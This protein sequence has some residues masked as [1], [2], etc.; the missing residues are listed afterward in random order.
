MERRSVVRTAA[1]RSATS[2]A[3]PVIA[4]DAMGGDH[5]P[6]EIVAGAAEAV[7][8]RSI[9]IR[10]VG[11]QDLIQGL[12]AAYPETSEDIAI[13]DA[14]EIVTMEEHAVSAVR[15]KLR[16][17][18]T[19][20]CEEVA[21]GRAAAVVSAGN[22]GAV[23]ASAIFGLGRL[24]GVD[25]PGIAIPFPTRKRTPVYVIDAGAVVD[26]RPMHLVQLAMLLRDYLVVVVGR[27]D[28][29]IGLLSNGQEPGKG[30]ALVRETY[31]LLRERSDLNFAGNVEANVIPEGDVDGVVCDGFS[32]NILLKAAEGT[33][34]LVQSALRDELS[35]RWYTKLLAAGLRPA[36]R[37]AVRSLDYREYGGAQLL[38][39]RYPVVIAHGRSD[40][41][42][43]A[44]AIVTAARAV[45]LGP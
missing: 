12:L 10:L 27:S 39:I 15:K 22:S 11:N 35:S 1:V 33:A 16:A 19:V 26:P 45:E 2:G 28:P 32:G 31:E 8:R 29:R 40:G 25:R 34:S 9:R 42:A 43:I 7:R 17:S 30:N 5:A 14:P 38:G 44:N 20:A 21:E 18:V 4:V 6:K 3:N 23:V 13:V 37:R 24:E 41:H 36:F